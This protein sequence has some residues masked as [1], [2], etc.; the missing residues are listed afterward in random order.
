[1]PAGAVTLVQRF[2]SVV[3]LTCTTIPLP[4]ARTGDNGALID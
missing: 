3:N 4:V 2:G 1:M